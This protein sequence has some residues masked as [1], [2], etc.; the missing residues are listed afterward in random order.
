MGKEKP[1]PVQ[2]NER[3]KDQETDSSRGEELIMA[4]VRRDLEREEEM[5]K[6]IAKMLDEK[7]LKKILL[8]ML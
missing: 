2:T 7:V 1:G 8:N 3:K 5:T 6:K 4:Q